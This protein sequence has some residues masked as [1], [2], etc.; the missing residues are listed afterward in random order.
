MKKTAKNNQSQLVILPGWSQDPATQSKWQ[1]LVVQLEQA[2]YQVLYLKLPGLTTPLDQV[3]QLADYRD[4]VLNQIKDFSKVVLI[5]HSFGGQLAV[6]VAA[7][8][9]ENLTALVL[10]GPAGL[11]DRRWFKVAK[12]ALFKLAAKWGGF[13]IGQT[14]S[15]HFF[16]KVLYK[17]A[18]EKDY[19][20]AS[21][22]LKQTMVAVLSQEIIKDLPKIKHPTLIIW[23]KQDRATPI[24]HAQIF[25]QQLEHSQ[26]CVL[27]HENHCPHYHQPQQIVRLIINFLTL[28]H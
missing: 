28:P 4:W 7:T 11:I 27:P 2:D 19:Y 10:I 26:L 17:L 6:S 8:N 14:K 3:W 9:P 5:G 24:H 15:K 23:G 25:N 20:L 13:L 18:R 21:P 1:P 16:Q 22:L 12:R